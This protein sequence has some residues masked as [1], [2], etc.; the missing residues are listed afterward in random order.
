MPLD[1]IQEKNLTEIIDYALEYPSMV[2]A[3]SKSNNTGGSLIDFSYGLYIGYISGVFFDKFL[4][5]NSR[6]LNDDEAWRLLLQD[7]KQKFRD[8]AK[9]QDAPET[10]ID[11]ACQP[12]ERF[13]VKATRTSITLLRLLFKNN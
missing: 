6:F 5:Q 9:N 2:L 8:H 1:V 3:A 4:L 7:S 10:K 13:A 11:F 12:T